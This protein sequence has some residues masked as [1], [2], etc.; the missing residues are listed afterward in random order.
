MAALFLL[1]TPL[2][3]GFGSGTI[4]VDVL[5]RYKVS[6]RSA[7]VGCSIGIVVSIATILMYPPG[8]AADGKNWG[9]FVFHGTVLTACLLAMLRY[10]VYPSVTRVMLKAWNKIQNW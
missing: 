5:R 10:C 1:G 8:S 4:A 7:F 3:V 6:T 2:L 9:K